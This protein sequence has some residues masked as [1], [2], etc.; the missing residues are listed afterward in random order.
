MAQDETEKIT[1]AID[2]ELSDWIRNYRYTKVRQTGDINF[3]IRQVIEDSVRL[4]RKTTDLEV[5][6]R[7]Q[8][9]RDNE[10]RRRAKKSKEQT[11]RKRK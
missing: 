7:P 3:T 9:V 10:K 6:S 2:A 5:M 1:I 4:L 8:I 11:E